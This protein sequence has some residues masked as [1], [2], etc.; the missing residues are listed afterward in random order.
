MST[1]PDYTTPKKKWCVMVYF[2]ADVDLES[3]AKADLKEMKA[4]GS[5][6]QV[7]LLAQ[8]NAGGPTAIRRYH[9]QKD[10]YLQEDLVPAIDANGDEEVLFNTDAKKDLLDFVEW[11]AQRSPAEHYA[12]I[13]W[14]HGQGWRAD[15][16]NPCYVPTPRN[17]TRPSPESLAKLIADN[18]KSNAARAAVRASLPDPSIT[19]ELPLH[20]K[21]GEI[22]FLTNA[23]VKDVLARIKKTLGGRNLDI[24]GMDACLM[25]M[26][27]ICC[28]VDDSVDYLVASE[29][30]VPDESWP[31]N[32]ILKE[33]VPHADQA[34]A[35]DV[36][37]LIVWKFVYDFGQKQKF[38]TQS[39]CQVGRKNESATREFTSAVA[40][41]VEALVAQM[42]DP[43]TRWATMIARAQAQSFY[44]TDYVDLFDFCRLLAINCRSEWLT[45]ACYDVM[46]AISGDRSSSNGAGRGLVI[47]YGT[48]GASL[49]RSFGVSVYFPCVAPVPECYGQ[50]EF[51]KRTQWHKFL[52]TFVHS[53]AGRPALFE[54]ERNGNSVKPPANAPPPAEVGPTAPATQPP[55]SK[56][57]KATGTITVE[58]VSELATVASNGKN[59]ALDASVKAASGD[60]S[61]TTYGDVVKTT[62]GD[63]VK[64]T[65]GDIVKT[66][67]GEPIKTPQAPSWIRPSM[68]QLLAKVVAPV[69]TEPVSTEPA[70]TNPVATN[71]K[72]NCNCHQRS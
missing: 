39:I 44:V 51:C 13:L 20:T 50:L 64:T 14:G 55:V 27:E 36:A 63:I 16:P 70:P 17:P 57:V 48:Y 34:N 72:C 10:T 11:C 5:S 15:N 61:K 43:E 26:A 40:R 6:S 68:P 8:L 49:K 30:V 7:D 58:P 31:Y 33:L 25:A 35:E 45:R 19:L 65:Y 1:S 9:L 12:L 71:G 21:S 29:D 2:A 54:P 3:A 23:D 4:A 67:Y 69:P 53:P 59:L 42:K 52:D 22:D 47:D 37:K 28:Q 32:S 66:T 18:P 24:L 60:A 56:E 38:V 41:L 46:K 62:Y